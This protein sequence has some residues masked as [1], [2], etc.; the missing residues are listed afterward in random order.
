MRIINIQ[1]KC[2]PTFDMLTP[3]NIKRKLPTIPP[4]RPY[5]AELIVLCVTWVICFP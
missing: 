3:T 2:I 1:A 5:N 4:I